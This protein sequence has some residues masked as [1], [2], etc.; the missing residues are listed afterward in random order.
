MLGD[1]EEQRPGIHKLSYVYDVLYL[2]GRL[3]WVL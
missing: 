3:L 1:G 2:L